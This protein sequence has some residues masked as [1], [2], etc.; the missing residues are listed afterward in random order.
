MKTALAG[1]VKRGIQANEAKIVYLNERLKNVKPVAVADIQVMGVS[2]IKEVITDAFIVVTNIGRLTKRFS[3]D[4]IFAILPVLAKYENPKEAFALAVQEFRE[5]SADE[6]DEIT[7]HLKAE[8]DIENDEIEARIERVLSL[9]AD[10][11]R[12]YKES[13]ALVADMAAVFN[14]TALTMREKVKEIAR[15]AERIVDQAF[16]I[17]DLVGETIASFGSLLQG[18]EDAVAAES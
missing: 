7:E 14:N 13:A 15:M 9:P 6:A 5:L 10:A 16:D 11:Y 2:K 8:F 4:P 18:G 12:E 1:A 17:I 3:V